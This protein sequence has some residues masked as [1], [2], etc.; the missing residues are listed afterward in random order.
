MKG[1]CKFDSKLCFS[2][3][4]IISGLLLV[5]SFAPFGYY[6][7]AELSLCLLLFVWFRSSAIL[8]FWY[9]WLFGLAFF[10]YGIYWVYISIHYYGQAP[11]IVAFAILSLL[12]TF[13][14]LYIGLLGY[15]L[16]RIYISCYYKYLFVFPAGWVLLEW[17]RGWFLSGF[18]WL[19]LGYG[20]IDSPLCGW[21]T[22]FGVYGVSFFIAQSAGALFYIFKY[23]KRNK[24][25]VFGSA[26]LVLIVWSLG[27][28]L[29]KISW[30]KRVGEPILA[31]LIQGN[32]SQEEKWKPDNLLPIT[33]SYIYQ[34]AKNLNSKIIVW[35]EAAIPAFPEDI[36]IYIKLL[37]VAAKRKNA[38]ILTG[39][40]FYDKKNGSYYNGLLAFGA[41][42]GRYYKRHLVP[43]GEYVPL[44]FILTWI[45]NFITIP[46]SD[47]SSGAKRQ[48]EFIVDKIILAPFICYEIAYPSLILD[49]L[50]RAGLLVTV[51]DDSW[52]GKSIASSQHLEIARMRSLEVGRFQIFAT[53]TGISSII[54]GSGKV[55]EETQEFKQ[56][57]LTKEVVVL[58]GSTPW[59][60]LGQY[61]LLPLLVAVLFFG[62]FRKKG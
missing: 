18:P 13:L 38:T 15:L 53:N 59:V 47:F 28:G 39:I 5:L 31:S 3:I 11:L 24:K 44:K 25:I 12:V 46:M 22:V 50:P 48:P 54:D 26:L 41:S 35:P 29:A 60:R 8:S 14:S 10:G 19:F 30:T 37:S 4:A 45:H 62:C 55:I 51:S 34:T 58:S 57:V 1:I 49:Y 6:L 43:F 2:L 9:G 33:N 36:W 40:P 7:F 56:T 42:D 27:F 32:V 61:I 21:A 17:L 52:F 23:W 20:H 16:N